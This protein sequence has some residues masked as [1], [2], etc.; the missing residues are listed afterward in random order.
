VRLSRRSLVILAGVILAL[1]AAGAVAAVTERPSAE[2]VSE[3]AADTTANYSVPGGLVVWMVPDASTLQPNGDQSADGT[4]FAR[5]RDA[6]GNEVVIKL[7]PGIDAQLWAGG[8]EPVLMVKHYDGSN[9]VYIYLKNETRWTELHAL[10]EDPA[11]VCSTSREV[12]Y[13]QIGDD[14]KLVFTDK[15]SGAELHVSNAPAMKGY[16]DAAV[17]AGAVAYDP[18][19]PV[20]TALAPIGDHV[21]SFSSNGQATQLTDYPSGLT[22]TVAGAAYVP[23]ATPSGDGLLYAAT[24]G[25]QKDTSLKV[26]AVDPASLRQ[27]TVADTG[28]VPNPS[29]GIPQL[30]LLQLL[31]TSDGVAL[32]VMERTEKP[33]IVEPAHLWLVR[34]NRATESKPLPERIGIKAACGSDS[35]IL[36]Y[37]GYARNVVSRLSLQTGEITVAKDMTAP[38]GT[39][40]LVAAD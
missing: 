7:G 9:H 10:S 11:S 14:S 19:R 33:E 38:D 12:V 26:L 31:P 40:I 8:S 18:S 21:F 22:E 27:V 37:G 17:D 6:T 23:A 29:D 15:G 4:V 32:F 5:T 1:G 35:S 34:G 36:F 2:T 39:W 24:V 30:N 16:S 13:T 28:W 25:F 20:I 3:A